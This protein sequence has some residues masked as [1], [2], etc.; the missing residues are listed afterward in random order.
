MCVYY[1]Y[2]F[3]YTYTYEYFTRTVAMVHQWNNKKDDRKLQQQEA[4]FRNPIKGLL[5]SK[6]YNI[7][8]PVHDTHCNKTKHPQTRI[9]TLPDFI[10]V[11]NTPLQSKHQQGMRKKEPV[12][13][14]WT[15]TPNHFGQKC[16]PA[17][18]RKQTAWNIPRQ[19][20][21]SPEPPS[22]CLTSANLSKTNK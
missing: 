3:I 6:T 10:N 16:R 4:P 15:C 5:N 2:I 18:Y 9:K 8:K 1:V 22:K 20:S 19:P 17:T 11:G 12:P 14:L 21:K 13:C 7:C